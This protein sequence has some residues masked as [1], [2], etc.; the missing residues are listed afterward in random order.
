MNRFVILILFLFFIQVTGCIETIDF[1]TNRTGNQLVVDGGVIDRP[2]SY[3][4]RLSLTSEETNVPEPLSGTQVTIVDGDGN[5]E[6][7]IESEPGLYLLHG[8][9]VRGVR[10][11]SY[12]I[13]IRLFD[14][15]FYRSVPETIPT[16]IG[17]DSS[18]FE[19]GTI[20]EQSASGRMIERPAVLIFTDTELPDQN[21]P[22]WLRWRVE[23]V[24]SFREGL[25]PVGL[26]PRT[27]YVAG[28]VEPQR[29]TLFHNSD[30]N[31][32]EITGRLMAMKQVIMHEFFIRHYFNVIQFSI[33]EQRH[34]YLEKVEEMINRTGTI[35]DTPPATIRGNVYNMEDEDEM[36]LGYFEA[37]AVDTSRTFTVRGDFDFYIPNPCGSSSSNTPQNAC[38]NC[39]NIPNS[40]RERPFYFGQP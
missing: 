14:G 3:E 27:C 17:R 22:V 1:D 6:E 19:V 16:A 28:H 29:I 8:N 37:A 9:T 13:E 39:I 10:G 35:F 32:G 36:V 31:T 24:Y 7:Y 40:T 26:E 21:K 20:E 30:L 11:Q 5:R 2:G 15:S 18:Y 38:R 23:N 33:T 4:L 12:H 25:S 34:R